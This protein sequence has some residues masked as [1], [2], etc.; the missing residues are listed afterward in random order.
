MKRMFI[1]LG[2]LL[3]LIPISSQT[4]SPEVVATSGNSFSLPNAQI[5]FTLGEVAISALSGGSN[6]L[7]QGFHQPEIHFFAVDKNDNEFTFSLYPNPTEQFV[8]VVSNSE[9]EMQ[10]HIYDAGGQAIEVSHVFTK[11][12]TLDMQ[13]MASGNY[14]MVITDNSGKIF[15]SYKI[16]K[17]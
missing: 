4:L 14:I 2:I 10:V 13:A 17:K 6:S 8:T 16:I 11:T 9:K 1:F 7:T 15:N 5:D 12:I 3:S